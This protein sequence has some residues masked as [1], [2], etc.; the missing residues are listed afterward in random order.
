[1]AAAFVLPLKQTQLWFGLYHLAYPPAMACQMQ[2]H[3][4]LFHV[5]LPIGAE[6]DLSAKLQDQWE[7]GV[8]VYASLQV[9]RLGPRIG[10]EQVMV[11][12]P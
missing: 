12:W 11:V 10:I 7:A 4:E 8:A 5:N 6:L 3:A 1:M 9:A 2:C